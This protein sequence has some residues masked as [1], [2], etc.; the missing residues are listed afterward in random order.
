MKPMLDA[1]HPW[2]SPDGL[3]AKVQVIST[4]RFGGVSQAPFDTLNL[5]LHVGDSPQAVAQN[6]ARLQSRL[7]S[8]PLWLNQVHGCRVLDA[9]HIESTECF[10]ADAAVTAASDVVLAIQTADCMPIVIHAHGHVLGVAHAGWRGLAHGVLT[11]LVDAMQQKLAC[12][13]VSIERSRWQAWIGPCIGQQAFQVGDEVR[14]VFIE[15]A[16]D[17]QAFFTPDPTALHKWRG[18][19]PG[20]ALRELQRLGIEQAKWCGLCTVSDAQERFFSYRRDGRT[21]RM[22]MLA[23]LV[24]D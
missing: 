23:W 19:L 20:L 1:Q 24:Q 18:D 12:A 13:S 17:N 9:D 8:E 4:T 15:K 22:A 3:T 10:E 7:P 16:Q 14:Q 2:V 21:G 6:R 11:A 5:G